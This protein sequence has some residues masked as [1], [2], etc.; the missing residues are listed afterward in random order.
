MKDSKHNSFCSETCPIGIGDDLLVSTTDSILPDQPSLL[1]LTSNKISLLYLSETEENRFRKLYQVM[2]D[3]NGTVVSKTT[4]IN[5]LLSHEDKNFNHFHLES[6]QRY[7]V[8][9]QSESKGQL[10]S[11]IYVKLFEESGDSYTSE[12]AVNQQKQTKEDFSEVYPTTVVSSDSKKIAV[13]WVE[14]NL[15]TN[16]GQIKFQILDSKDG[17]IQFQ[18]PKTL[19]TQDQCIYSFTNSIPLSTKGIAIAWVQRCVQDTSNKKKNN[20]YNPDLTTTTTTTTTELKTF[21]IGWDGEKIAEKPFATNEIDPYFQPQLSANYE[22][23]LILVAWNT[24]VMKSDPYIQISRDVYYSSLKFDGTIV[25]DA[26]L[27]NKADGNLHYSPAIR[28][29]ENNYKSIFVVVWNCFNNNVN[30]HDL[31]GIIYGTDL[32]PIGEAFK[33]NQNSNG[34]Q[35]QASILDSGYSVEVN[36]EKYP[37]FL[38]TWVSGS[39]DTSSNGIFSRMF[40]GNSNPISDELKINTKTELKQFSPVLTLNKKKA[41]SVLI[42]WKS[43]SETKKENTIFAK[44]IQYKRIKTKASI[45]DQTINTL[46]FWD[47]SLEPDLFNTNKQNLEV[48]ATLSDNKK[49]PS[50]LSFDQAD[51]RLYGKSP[52]KATSYTIQ[53]TA[54]DP[55]NNKAQ[56]QF[57]LKIEDVSTFRFNW[58]LFSIISIPVIVVLLFLIYIYRRKKNLS[59]KSAYKKLDKNYTNENDFEFSTENNSLEDDFNENED[60]IL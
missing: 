24:L 19:S 7:G 18:N 56:T 58:T 46:K 34:Q 47:F 9:W 57:N 16:Y 11:R 33:I 29:I 6:T 23:E 5:D 50:W 45:K 51:W 42:A 15:T 27:I 38:V 4:K 54:E 59:K 48:T 12:I 30:D 53:I 21:I 25:K 44:Q 39:K 31:Y 26:T 17:S 32:S 60:N 20:K 49:L 1:E 22:K 28:S 36:K 3:S 13:A 52:E 14:K 2:L 41:N 10:S 55:C 35:T 8:T 43:G 40:I 37:E